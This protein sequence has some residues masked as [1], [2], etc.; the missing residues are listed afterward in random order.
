MPLEKPK[1]TNTS[2]HQALNKRYPRQSKCE[3]CGAEGSTAF[4][5]IHGR[6]YSLN[7]K[8][9]LELCQLCHN[10]YDAHTDLTIGCSC[11][12]KS[13]RYEH[14]RAYEAI[15]RDDAILKTCA[16]SECG[17]EF[18]TTRPKKIYHSAACKLS[19]FRE[20]N[21]IVTRQEPHYSICQRSGCGKPIPE[22]KK[23]STKYCSNA[24][25][26]KVWNDGHKIQEKEKRDVVRS[27]E[28]EKKRKRDEAKE[29]EKYIQEL[30]GE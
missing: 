19:A 20:R 2:L 26:Q 4:A 18:Y 8:D 7:R 24:C 3:N 30:M 21:G 29:I 10:S 27:V 25:R 17:F 23:A 5:L 28:K 11:E 22:N 1:H 9:Y 14:G 12:S 16:Y 6:P 15:S 13:K